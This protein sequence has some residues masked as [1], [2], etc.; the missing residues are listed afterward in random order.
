MFMQSRH[1]PYEEPRADAEVVRVESTDDMP[2]WMFCGHTAP[3]ARGRSPRW[4]SS[5]VPASP[6]QS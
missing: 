1:D 5:F 4:L 2:D 6:R 3:P